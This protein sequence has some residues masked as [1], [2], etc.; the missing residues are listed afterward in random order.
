MRK[1]KLCFS[2]FVICTT[3]MIPRPPISTLRVAYFAYTIVDAS[4]LENLSNYI[5]K[6]GFN[7]TRI[8]TAEEVNELVKREFQWDD[9]MLR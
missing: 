9:F 6:E 2:I 5:K 3:N 4:Y 7:Y 8:K 1:E